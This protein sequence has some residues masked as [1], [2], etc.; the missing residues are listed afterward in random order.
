MVRQIGNA[1]LGASPFGYVVVSGN[2][3][4]AGHRST[5]HRD[6]T[7]VGSVD[8]GARRLAFCHR[9]EQFGSK[10][11]RVADKIAGRSAIAEDLSQGRARLNQLTRQT[12]H[13]EVAV[14]AHDHALGG[15]EHDEA[16]RHV[17]NG[18]YQLQIALAQ[19]AIGKGAGEAHAEDGQRGAGNCDRQ[20]R[21]RD[22]ELVDHP[23]RIG[24]DL[25]RPH[26]GE[27]MRDDCQREENRGGQD[28]PSVVAPDGDGERNAA[29]QDPEHDRSRHQLGGPGDVSRQLERRHA[30]VMHGGHPAAD[31]GAA[32]HR[33]P[34]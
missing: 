26:R 27:M 12:V 14:I 21:R 9:L 1:L 33:E 34:A 4:A 8:H 22:G 24:N 6:R 30:G 29:E 31:D 20:H 10:L 19:A 28:A 15:V 17:V 7:A 13:F 16:L 3:G 25:D 2:P 18:G 23:R 32:D 11:V 5:C